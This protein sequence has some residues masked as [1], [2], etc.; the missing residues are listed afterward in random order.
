MIATFVAQATAL[1][2]LESLFP[3]PLPVPGVKLGLANIVTLVALVV[4]DFRTAMQITV[5]R[6]ILG[7]LLAGTLFGMGFFMSFAGA[8]TAATFMAVGL[9]FCN[10]LGAVGISILGAVFHNVGQLV[11]ATFVLRFPGIFLY[12]PLM[13]VFSVPT[14]LLTGLVTNEL[15]KYINKSNQFSSMASD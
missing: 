12:L 13:L 14:G 4:F 5:L 6:T 2:Y 1:H 9:R 11:M 7:S 3:N 15:V 10:V 8:V